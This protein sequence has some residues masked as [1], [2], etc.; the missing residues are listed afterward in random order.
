V[1]Y[2]SDLW[3]RMQ[4]INDKQYKMS[5]DGYLKLFQLRKHLYTHT[6]RDDYDVLLIDEAQDLTPGNSCIILLV[7]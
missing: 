2:A 7:S 6:V 1:D 3:Q 4:N 5:H